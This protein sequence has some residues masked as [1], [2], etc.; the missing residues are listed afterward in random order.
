MSEVLPIL[1]TIQKF[2]QLAK[3]H[4]HLVTPLIQ[5]RKYARTPAIVEKDNEL[6]RHCRASKYKIG[7]LEFP[8]L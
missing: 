7:P 6:I 8:S 3:R 2:F 4:T 5:L 1:A